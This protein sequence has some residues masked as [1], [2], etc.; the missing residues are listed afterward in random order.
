MEKHPPSGDGV[1]MIL[2]KSSALALLVCMLTAC[3]TAAIEM[4]G[5]PAAIPAFKT[6]HIAA[7]EFV[8]AT[9]VSPEQRDQV[10]KQLRGAAA[11]ALQKRG[12]R[13]ATDADVLVDLA[14]MSR[15][16]FGN[17]SGSASGLHHV[18]T[19]VLDTSRP[20]SPTASEIPPSGVGREGDLMM[21]L[22]DAKTGKTLWAAASNGAASTP[23]EALRKA[24]S[25]YAA[26]ADKLPKA[27]E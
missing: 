24:R 9:D 11:S 1:G 3:T 20:V 23:S 17:E 13:E 8:F 18:D 14:A 2:A 26:I 21:T 10:D 27:H 4:S 6:F 25:A 12:Y 15:P 22:R 19:T 16:T 7:A 5:D